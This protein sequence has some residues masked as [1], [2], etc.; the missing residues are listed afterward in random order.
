V[1][2]EV[3]PRQDYELLRELLLN[4]KERGIDQYVR[5]SSLTGLTGVFTKIGLTGLPLATI[6]ITSFFTLLSFFSMQGS[7]LFDLAR[8]TLGAFIGSYVQKQ[9]E[10][11]QPAASRRP[12]NPTA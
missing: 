10:Q 2:H 7:Q 8:L 3:I 4:D 12:A 9:V 1:S 6:S 5:L 11:R